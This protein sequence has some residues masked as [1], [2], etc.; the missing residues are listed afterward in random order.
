[1]AVR[2]GSDCFGVITAHQPSQIL[3]EQFTADQPDVRV[4]PTA[5]QAGP[6]MAA[7]L[8]VVESC[9]RLKISVRDYLTALLPGLCN[10]SI[11]RIV[12]HSPSAWA[13]QHEQSSSHLANHIRQS[14]LDWFPIDWFLWGA[15]CACGILCGFSIDRE[16]RCRI[17]WRY[18]D[19]QTAQ[20][21]QR[22]GTQ[23]AQLRDW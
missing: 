3:Q 12:A 17:G 10:V 1:M 8:S 15:L 14:P 11:Q 23:P 4:V 7:I 20:R 13:T 6:K 22:E 19:V 16:Q 2:F 9:R 21:Q 5:S 18:E